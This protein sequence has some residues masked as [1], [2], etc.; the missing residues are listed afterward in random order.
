MSAIAWFRQCSVVCLHQG[1]NVS[2]FRGCLVERITQDSSGSSAS[3]AAT[4]ASDRLCAG[5]DSLNVE[6]SGQSLESSSGRSE[7]GGSESGR[8][9]TAL[10]VDRTNPNDQEDSAKNKQDEYR[11]RHAVHYP[12]GQTLGPNWALEIVGETSPLLTGS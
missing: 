3:A 4:F 12:L 2:G 9:E 5:L 6:L 7:S 11:K 8:S 10:N 1:A